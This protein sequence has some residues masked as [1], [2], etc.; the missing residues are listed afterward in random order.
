MMP[1]RSKALRSAAASSVSN[2]ER[3]SS[4]QIRRSIGAFAFLQSKL[5]AAAFAGRATPRRA[6]SIEQ[7]VTAAMKPFGKTKP[8]QAV[9][10]VLS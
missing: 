6:N 4:S 5:G 7:N 10:Y 1:E 9:A 2:V 3:V 8:L